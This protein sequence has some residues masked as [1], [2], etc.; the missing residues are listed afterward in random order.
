MKEYSKEIIEID[1][2][3]YTLFLNRQGVIAWEKY[4][5]EENA[6]IEQLRGKYSALVE[7]ENI[8]LTD[9]T[10]PFQGLEQFDDVEK[11]LDLISKSFKKLY[12]I[13]LYTEH[14]FTVSKANE[15]YDKAILEYG[16]EQLIEL[17]KQMLEDANKDKISKQELKNL[18]ALRPT[19]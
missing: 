11:D 15:L 3:N 5:K 18:T 1:N 4:C 12:W 7:N 14:K 17:G 19:K 16:E 8:E 2:Q 6:K 13:M 9:E 10:N